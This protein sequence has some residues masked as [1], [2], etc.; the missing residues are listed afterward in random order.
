MRIVF[1]EK[2]FEIIESSNK[3]FYFSNKTFYFIFHR[4]C[5]GG[6]IRKG[7]YTKCLDCGEILPRKLYNLY[8]IL[9]RIKEG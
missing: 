7:C 4:I 5:S 3:T 8:K 6:D 1:E 2:N 9:V